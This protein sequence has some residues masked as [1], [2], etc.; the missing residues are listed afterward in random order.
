[1]VTETLAEPKSIILHHI[2]KGEANAIKKKTLMQLCDL[3]D[4]E[5]RLTIIELLN[6]FYPICS[7]TGKNAGYYIADTPEEIK[8]A[9]QTLKNYGISAIMHRAA[10]KK[11][12]KRME[13]PLPTLDNGQIRMI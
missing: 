11:C 1:M 4:R 10:L 2:K 9:M 12:L 3:G 5:L 7:S 8:D 13:I 6:D